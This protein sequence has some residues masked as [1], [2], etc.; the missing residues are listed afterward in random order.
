MYST[1]QRSKTTL[2]N[3]GL[4]YR[5]RLLLTIVILTVSAVL[6]C[7]GLALSPVF[8]SDILQEKIFINCYIQE[9]APDLSVT[10]DHAEAYW[11]R[12]SDVS[13]HRYYGKNGAMGIFGAQEHYDHHGKQEGRIWGTVPTAENPIL[14]PELAEAYW[15]RY[16]E[17]EQSHIW[18]R[19]SQLGILGP[20]DHFHYRGKDFG[21]IWG[22]LT[23]KR[24]APAR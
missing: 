20:R 12:Y 16:P 13:N 6:W 23:E 5:F 21:R 17:I 1:G 8:E 11:Q 10:R 9:H 18:G 2:K 7:R 14:E 19:K 3:T 4:I 15:H 24:Q 22:P